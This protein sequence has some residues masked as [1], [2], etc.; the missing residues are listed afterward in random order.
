MYP[1]F[2]A[3]NNIYIDAALKPI[4]GLDKLKKTVKK[5]GVDA[6]MEK[7]RQNIDG[8]GTGSKRPVMIFA[9]NPGTGKT[10]IAGIITSK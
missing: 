10:T 7:L 4:V 8:K 5:F 9:G 6:T 2:A 1:E 3:A